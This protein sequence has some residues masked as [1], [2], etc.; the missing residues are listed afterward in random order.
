MRRSTK[1]IDLREEIQSVIT[2]NEGRGRSSC[3]EHLG[4]ADILCDDCDLLFS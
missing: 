2:S 3:I 4:M 1:V